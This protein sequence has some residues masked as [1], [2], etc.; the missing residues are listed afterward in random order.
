M[1]EVAPRWQVGDRLPAEEQRLR[2]E[3]GIGSLLAA[4]L[5]SRG[6][7]DPA[8]ADR[9]LNAS[10][11]QFHD[12][13]L[14]PDYRPAADAILGAIERRERIFVH[15]D[16]D[17]DGIS[18]SALLT[19]F[20][21]KLGADLEVHVPHRQ[22][23][24]YGIH[25]SAVERAVQSGA[26]LFLTCDCGI[27]AHRQID[28]LNEAGIPV[29]VT[30][31]HMVGATLPNAV[32]VVNPMRSDSAYPFAKLCGAGIVF[33]LCAGLAAEKG[34]DPR[35]YYKAYADLATLGTVCDVMPLT[36]ENRLIVKL[37]LQK[38][39]ETN[40]VG[41]R[42]LTRL[43]RDSSKPISTR[44]IS[45]GIGPRLNAAGRIDDSRIA[46]DL[47][48]EQD[49]TRAFDLAKTL[50][51]LNQ[52]RRRQQDR[53]FDEAC[54]MVLADGLEEAPMLVLAKEGWHPGIVGI[55]AGKLVERFRRPAI[56]MGIVDGQARGSARSIGGFD[57]GGAIVAQRPLIVSGG[58]HAEAAGVTVE[59]DNLSVFRKAVEELASEALSGMPPLADVVADFAVDADELTLEAVR[60]LGQLEPIGE[61]NYPLRVY[62]E[63]LQVTSI[64]P[65]SKPEHCQGVVISRSGHS[66]ETIVFGCGREFA[67]LELGCRIDAV[68]APEYDTY[69]PREPKVKLQIHHFRP[70]PAG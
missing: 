39:L 13:Q 45:F 36:G 58:G 52:D 16:Y 1:V 43:A 24:G 47:L 49:P 7:T 14:L 69:R 61:A 31:H 41:L 40:K 38:L 32:A 68:L 22:R 56:V 44:D 5:A 55:V 4:A 53:I 46:L 67:N 15:G 30:D 2:A 54:E 29:V 37:G 12:P 17:V 66:F 70:N 65:T 57:I 35:Q 6:V 48:L 33:K 34:I 25:D 9:F 21:R 62:I 23:E 26:K 64:R 51:Q 20:L 19:R 10:F 3:L 63:N 18:A 28:A 60:E 50:D 11:D 8:E 59:T 27:G 42:E